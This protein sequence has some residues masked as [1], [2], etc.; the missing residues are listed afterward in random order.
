MPGDCAGPRDPDHVR[1]SGAIGRK[2]RS[3][4]DNGAM[5][6]R[7]VHHRLKTD[8][9]REWRPKLLDWIA[10]NPRPEPAA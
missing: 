6:C 2:S 1:A 7:Y 3:T 10:A 8:N 4:V 9:G 5:L